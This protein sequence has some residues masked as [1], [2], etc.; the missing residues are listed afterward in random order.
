[1]F[2]TAAITTNKERWA[3]YQETNIEGTRT[4]L[5][6]AAAPGRTTSST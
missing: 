3:A 6:A 2:H 5:E 1:M 4:V